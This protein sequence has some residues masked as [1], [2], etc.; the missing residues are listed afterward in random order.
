MRDK[1]AVGDGRSLG[2]ALISGK[3]VILVAIIKNG[4]SIDAK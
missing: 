4:D 3:F 1:G 2:I